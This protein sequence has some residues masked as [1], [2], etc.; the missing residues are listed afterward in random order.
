MDELKLSRLRGCFRAVSKMQILRK[1]VET[2]F[3]LPPPP[4]FLDGESQTRRNAMRSR[5]CLLALSL[6]IPMTAFAQ[7][8]AASA[9]MDPPA[10][11]AGSAATESVAATATATS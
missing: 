5:N 11:P 4:V 10:A 1:T 2:S 9:P 6:L 3:T 7:D 8:P